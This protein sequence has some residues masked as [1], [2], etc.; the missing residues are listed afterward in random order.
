MT[1]LSK[2]VGLSSPVS[3]E[4][5]SAQHQR[6]AKAERREVTFRQ[7]ASRDA[8]RSRTVA[9]AAVLDRPATQTA[10]WEQLNRDLVAAGSPLQTMDKAGS[11]CSPVWLALGHSSS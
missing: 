5:A 3:R 7:A 9:R 8:G 11:L 10:D 1:V 2:P 6:F 4:L